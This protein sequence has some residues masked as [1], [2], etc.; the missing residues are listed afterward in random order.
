MYTTLLIRNSLEQASEP[1][2]ELRRQKEKGTG[3]IIL[4]LSTHNP[5]N[6]N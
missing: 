1:S 6:S 4:F 2:N 5:N 3:E